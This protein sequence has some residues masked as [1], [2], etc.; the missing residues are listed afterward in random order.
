MATSASDTTQPSGRSNDR[1][2]EKK[3]HGFMAE[4]DNVDDLIDAYLEF[5][6][7]ILTSG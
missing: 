1:S 7:Q 6:H 5:Y 2:G 3:L 4:F